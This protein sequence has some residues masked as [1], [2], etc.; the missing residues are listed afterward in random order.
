MRSS[1][2]RTPIL[3]ISPIGWPI[4][5]SAGKIAADC[6]IASYP[7]T[8]M[9]SGTLQRTDGAGRNLI[10]EGEDGGN[11]ASGD[12]SLFQKLTSRRGA[13]IRPAIAPHQSLRGDLET[14]ISQC[15]LEPG[16]PPGAGGQVA[17]PNQ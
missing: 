1:R 12:D 7:I 3:P 6:G 14:G 8:E 15:A 10:V 5:V 16:D 17:R 2:S 13:S 11:G 9:P 4:V